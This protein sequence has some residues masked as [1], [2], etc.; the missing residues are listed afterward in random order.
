LSITRNHYI[1]YLL[2]IIF[3]LLQFNGADAIF[4]KILVPLSG[5]QEQMYL[6]DVELMR[7]EMQ[8][9]IPSKVQDTVFAKAAALFVQKRKDI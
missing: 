8:K 6:R 7:L 2:E 9:A 1:S 5:Q 4:R 3:R